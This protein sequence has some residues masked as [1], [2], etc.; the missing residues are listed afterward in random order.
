MTINTF[1]SILLGWGVRDY[2]S[3]F[4]AARRSVFEKIHLRGDY[5]E[6]CIDL[7]GRAQRLG[8]RVEEVPYVCGSRL[9]GESKTGANVRDY[10]RR[11]WKYVVTVVKLA[12]TRGNR[13]THRNSP[14]SP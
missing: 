11:G 6:Y 7:L 10:L 4:V 8:F 9:H 3:G 2:T 14:E 5:G 13:G 12:M 1:A